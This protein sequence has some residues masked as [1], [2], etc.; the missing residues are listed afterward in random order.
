M[1]HCKFI[2]Y[3]RL[4]HEVKKKD[5]LIFFEMVVTDDLVKYISQRINLYFKQ[6]LVGKVF[7][8][9]PVLKNSCHKIIKMIIT[10]M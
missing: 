8:N 4:R 6:N 10:F 9:I 5:Q 2:D 1:V 7:L 3:P